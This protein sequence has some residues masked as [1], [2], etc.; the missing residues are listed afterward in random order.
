M[1]IYEL[2]MRV[3][4]T[5]C[6]DLDDPIELRRVSSRVICFPST[7]A[8]YVLEDPNLFAPHIEAMRVEVLSEVMQEEQEGGGAVEVAQLK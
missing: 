4:V 3:T 1:K 7:L 8:R 6:K 5:V 2:S